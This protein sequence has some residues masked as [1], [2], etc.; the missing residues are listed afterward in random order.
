MRAIESRFS[1]VVNTFPEA[2]IP[3]AIV[4]R[5]VSDDISNTLT[6][7]DAS[8][9][10]RAAIADRRD[11]DVNHYIQV[12]I[13]SYAARLRK[14]FSPEEFAQLFRLESQPGLFDQPVES[15]QSKW[16]RCQ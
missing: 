7:T 12:L 15:I 10:S 11:Y 9:S 1:F 6:D 13:T 2:T 5:R 16:I 8:S 14:A 3:T 4:A